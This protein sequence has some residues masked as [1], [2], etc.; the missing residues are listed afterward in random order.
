MLLTDL[1]FL[2]YWAGTA[3]GV[4]SVG[5]DRFLQQWNWSFLG[6]DLAAI[7][8]G[9]AGLAAR[10]GAGSLPMIT[11]SLSLTSAAGLMALNFYVLHGDYD[12]AWWLPNLW[13]VGFPIVALLGIYRTH[14]VADDPTAWDPDDPMRNHPATGFG[15][16]AEMLRALLERHC[17]VDNLVKLAMAADTNELI[18]QVDGLSP[19]PSERRFLIEQTCSAAVTLARSVSGVDLEPRWVEFG[20]ARPAHADAYR[21]LLSGDHRF[22]AAT[23][24]ICFG[25][26]A[27]ERSTA[28]TDQLH[29][30]DDTVAAVERVLRE[31]LRQ[32]M[33]KPLVAK[34]LMMSERTLHRR[35]AEAG[36]KFGEIRDRLRL[37][38][39]DTLLRESNLPI[40][41]VA[42][43]LGF[44]DGREFRRAYQRWTG[45]N[46][47]EIRRS[48]S[49]SIPAHAVAA[50][51]VMALHRSKLFGSALR[52][53]N[54]RNA[55]RPSGYVATTD[56]IPLE[57]RS[58]VRPHYYQLSSQ[59]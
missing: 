23:T 43:Q 48:S 45:D 11:V 55:I 20:Y 9:L 52:H 41:V 32:T 37:Q 51:N 12:L 31:N 46:A 59:R 58:L 28:Q 5:P 22:G 27:F 17:V 39:A 15:S 29:D 24:R 42:A 16:A 35:L 50:G 26:A 19:E 2:A 8:L 25:T 18:L 4:L 38:R 3:L 6:L 30:P 7:G 13:L 33:P 36:E 21:Y 53:S 34:R 49:R 47:A 57:S 10:S 54:S 56:D 40:A 1:G 14:P 44:G